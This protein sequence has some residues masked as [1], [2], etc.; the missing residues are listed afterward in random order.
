MLKCGSLRDE[1]EW[2]EL[3]ELKYNALAGANRDKIVEIY[4]SFDFN[5]NFSS[6]LYGDGKKLLK[7][8]A[9]FKKFLNLAKYQIFLTKWIKFSQI[10]LEI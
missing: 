9:K 2:T 10:S 4:H 5:Q 1:T 7:K 3:T 8:F 6:N